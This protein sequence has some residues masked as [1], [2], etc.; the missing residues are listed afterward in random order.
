[1]NKKIKITF[2]VNIDL[3]A[4][5]SE[6][7]IESKKEAIEDAPVEPKG[8][9][10]TF[11]KGDP[12]KPKVDDKPNIQM[13]IKELPPAPAKETET[14]GEVREQIQEKLMEQEGTGK[15]KRL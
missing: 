14:P 2:T 5:M 11:C 4:W 7:D 13:E 15:E 1:M 10:E 9:R 3:D 8:E 12:S 6:Y